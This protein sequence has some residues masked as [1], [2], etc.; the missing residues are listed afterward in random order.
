[1]T[2]TDAT[3]S[4]PVD[5]TPKL[6]PQDAIHARVMAMDEMALHLRRGELRAKTDDLTID[7]LTELCAV[8]ASLRKKK[9]GP[10]ANGDGPKTRKRMTTP[11]KVDVRALKF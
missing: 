8:L 9:S 4:K 10:P 2:D 7:E 6:D 5:Q 3:I 11:P 1:M